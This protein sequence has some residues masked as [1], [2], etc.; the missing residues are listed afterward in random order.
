MS[1]M[2]DF[3]YY[4]APADTVERLDPRPSEPCL[5]GDVPLDVALPQC[6]IC[7]L[8]GY[9][10]LIPCEE[11]GEVPDN[12][13]ILAPEVEAAGLT[14]I[15]DPESG[16]GMEDYFFRGC[17]K[18]LQDGRFIVPHVTDV[19]DIGADGLLEPE[20]FNRLFSEESMRE[21]ARTPNFIANQESVWLTHCN[22]F[23]GYLGEWGQ[24][25]FNRNAP[26][27]N[28]RATFNAV[29]QSISYRVRAWDDLGDGFGFSL[30]RCLHCGQLRAYFAWD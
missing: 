23:M 10:L 4:L 2:T 14:V 19:G 1:A 8:P 27:H 21:L 17:L 16:R 7:D 18:C 25:D 20:A 9:C 12:W 29:D 11:D 30:F 6:S 26:D 28:G 15:P 5:I 22:D 3:K 13:F 24:D